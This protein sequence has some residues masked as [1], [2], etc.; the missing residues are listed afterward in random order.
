MSGSRL[1]YTAGGL[2]A[3]GGIVKISHI[4]VACMK[5]SPSSAASHVAVPHPLILSSHHVQCLK[6]NGLVVIDDVLS[7][8]ELHST[9]AEVLHILDHTNRFIDDPNDDLTVRSDSILWISEK[10]NQGHKSTLSKALMQTL[11]LLRSIPHE[12]SSLHGYDEATLGVPLSNQLAC[13]DGSGAKYVAHRDTPAETGDYE[14]ILQPGIHDRALTMV[15]YLNE[16]SWDS[17]T[18]DGENCDGNLR[19][20]MNTDTNDYTGETAKSVINIEPIGGRLVIFDSKRV[21]HAV[22]P[23]SQ[24]RIALTSW[25]GGSHSSHEWMRTMFIPFSEIDW[26]YLKNKLSNNSFY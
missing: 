6:E 21:L 25:I 8:D 20:F 22:M 10:I 3:W 11:R 4:S 9:R 16:S 24:R 23:T 2:A 18:S 7:A 15:L 12:L 26:Q 5:E 14:W 19:C 1:L 17:T 13:Y